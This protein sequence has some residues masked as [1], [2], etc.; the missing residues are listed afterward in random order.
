MRRAHRYLDADA[1][2][3]FVPGLKTRAELAT[4]GERFRGKHLVAGA[5][6]GRETWLPPAEFYAMGFRQVVFP[7]L[8]I[9][10]VAQCLDAALAEFRRH[11]D[12][13]APMPD[14]AAAEHAQ[15]VLKEAL[16]FDKWSGIG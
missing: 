5:F 9:T 11:V 3:L 14:F 2:A 12:G 6:E 1:H 10:R 13:V 15:A 16:Q 4:L 7:S 8:L